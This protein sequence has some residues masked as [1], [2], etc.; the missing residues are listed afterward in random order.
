MEGVAYGALVEA[1]KS[2]EPITA[3][4][5]AEKPT[6]APRRTAKAASATESEDEEQETETPAETVEAEAL[7]EPV[8]AQPEALRPQP[9]GRPASLLPGRRPPCL[10][11]RPNR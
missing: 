8:E 7:A 10:P 11:V 6:R 3:E 2:V 4:A 9:V 1:A 5:E